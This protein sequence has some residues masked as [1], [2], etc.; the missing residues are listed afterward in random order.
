M[1]NSGAAEPTCLAVRALFN[2]GVIKL[3]TPYPPMLQP[4]ILCEVC[5][6]VLVLTRFCSQ[7]D[8]LVVV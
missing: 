4:K 2:E 1:M 8:F 3:Y 5:K 7:S 6:V